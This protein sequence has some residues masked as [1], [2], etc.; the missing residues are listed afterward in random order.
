MSVTDSLALLDHHCHGLVPTSL[1]GG[2]FRLLATESDHLAPIPQETLDSPIGLA[3]RSRCAPLL[4]LPRHTEIDAYLDRRAELG[5]DEVHR[6]LMGASG[7]SRLL[8]DT[9][10][11]ASPVASPPTMTE[12]TGIPAHE[13]VRL[14]RIAE[15]VAPA[16]TAATFA[17]DFLT[18][19]TEAAERAIG[20]KSI[21][22]YRF[23]FDI[24]PEPPSAAEVVEAAG[25]WFS[26]A[27]ATG[28]WRLTE[29][30]I[31]RHLLWAAIPF[32]KPIQLHTGY[33]DSDIQLFRA[34]PSRATRF[35]AATVESGAAFTLLH[36]YPFIREAGILSQLF[37]HV[38][39]D[40]GAVTHYL[41]PSAGVAI[42]HMMEVAP[43]TK[44][45]FSSDA[46]GLAEQYLISSLSWRTQLGRL[47]D[48]WIADD[49][50]TA[51]EARRIAGL[52]ASGNAARLYGI[53]DHA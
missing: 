12:I 21:I 46:Y 50:T 44:I 10:F 24:P 45:L 25:R 2:E 29:P 6:R 1:T 34:D 23:G 8:I 37:P 33:G 47:L 16:S 38:Y 5:A 14:E 18:A 39:C 51:E 32:G 36:C 9:G 3:I 7:I 49:W 13:I 17:I 30:V 42:G 27:S 52:I 31:L 15:R 26:T 35:F 20:F 4:D 19:L 11:E 53:E 48:S 40:V 28:N 22:V 43:F 41:G